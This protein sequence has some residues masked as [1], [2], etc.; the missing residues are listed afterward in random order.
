MFGKKY[1]YDNLVESI[2]ETQLAKKEFR[3]KPS[4]VALLVI[5]IQSEFCDPDKPRGNG[6]T[7][8]TAKRVKSA[9]PA[10]RKA[11][12]PV[13]AIYMAKTKSEDLDF[14]EFV[15]NI[16]DIVIRKTE[17]SAFDKKND[18]N[19]K[20]LLR[21]LG[22]KTVLTCGTN[23]NGCVR[24]TL[25][26]AQKRGFN[27]F[28]LEDLSGNDRLNVNCVIPKDTVK[29]DE[30]GN[31]SNFEVIKNDDWE[32]ITNKQL[33]E[34]EIQVIKSQPL[35]EKTKRRQLGKNNND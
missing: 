25:I 9:V 5:D 7:H 16:N 31:L 35:L 19:L 21:Q 14:Y 32:E 3:Y 29:I 1:K 12:I 22:I 2:K 17:A 20:K 18:Q 11:S 30:K 28:L 15:P 23:K 6:E 26:D 4:E 13:F 10:F 8:Q 27:A 24:K 34:Y 33:K